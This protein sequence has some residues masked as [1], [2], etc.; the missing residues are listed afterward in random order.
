ML[1]FCVENPIE[2]ETGKEDFLDED[3]LDIKL[4]AWKMYFGGTMNQYG[5]GI[6]ILLIT[7]DGSHIP[8]AVKLNFEVTNNMV[9][10]EACIAK[11]EALQELG[12]K[13]AEVFGDLTLVIAQA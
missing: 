2:G 7:P 10:Y 11:M 5:N 3:I 12:I 13:E 4:G 8:L 6:G 1:D 9:E